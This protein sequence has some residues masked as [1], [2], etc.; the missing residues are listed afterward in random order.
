MSLKEN[1]YI[2]IERESD[3]LSSAFQNEI[4]SS[5]NVSLYINNK[6]MLIHCLNKKVDKPLNYN[7]LLLSGK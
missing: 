7:C 3:I 1:I 2:L 6:L 5:G 4:L